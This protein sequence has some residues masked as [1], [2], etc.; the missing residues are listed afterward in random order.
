VADRSG[1]TMEGTVLLNDDFNLA[2]LGKDGWYHS[3]PKSDVKIELHDPIAIH[4]ELLAKYTDADMH[5]L[6]T[7]LETLK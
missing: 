4:A 5:N 1:N 3:W 7:Y 2:I 6:F